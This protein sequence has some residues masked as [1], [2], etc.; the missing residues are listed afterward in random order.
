MNHTEASKKEIQQ[1]KIQFILPRLVPYLTVAGLVL[2][3]YGLAQQSFQVGAVLTALFLYQMIC[4]LLQSRKRWYQGFLWVV[5]I[6]GVVLLLLQIQQ[7]IQ[8]I[9][10]LVNQVIAQVNQVYDQA[11]MSL[12]ATGCSRWDVAL[13]SC[14]TGIFLLQ[15]WNGILSRRGKLGVSFL[16]MVL[17]LGYSLLPTLSSGSGGILILLSW[18]LCWLGTEEEP[19]QL[20]Y[21]RIGL[22]IF[23]V[24]LMFVLSYNIPQDASSANIKQ[25]QQNMKEKAQEFR[26]GSDTLPE[27]DLTKA[28]EI[29]Q[30]DEKRLSISYDK[31]G[32]LY[33]RGYVGGTYTGSGWI[34]LPKSNYIQ[35]NTNGML[36]WLGRKHF[37]TTTQYYQYCTV[38]DYD[39]TTMNLKVTNLNSNRKYVYAP[40]ELSQVSNGLQQQKMDW[41]LQSTGLFGTGSYQMRVETR[42]T[43]LEYMPLEIGNQQEQTGQAFYQANQVY[44]AFVQQ[45][46]TQIDEELKDYLNTVFFQDGD[47]ENASLSEI[48]ARIRLKLQE[49]MTYRDNPVAYDG[50]T[51]FVHWV[52][53]DAREGN[54]E[55]YATI[56]ALAYRSQGIPAR[57]VE[58]YYLSAGDASE[59]IKQ[60][61]GNIVLTTKNA[62]A[63]LEIY[64]EPIGWIPIEVAPGFYYAQYTTQQILNQPQT[65]VSIENEDDQEQLEGSTAD[66]L[67]SDGNKQQNTETTR[68]KIRHITGGLLL[69]ILILTALLMT[70]QIQGSLRRRRVLTTQDIYDQVTALLHAMKL[71]VNMYYPLEARAMVLEAFP[72]MH[73]EEYDRFITLIQKEIFGKE[74]LKP[75]E[76]RYLMEFRNRLGEAVFRR[77]SLWA[78]IRIHYIEC[79]M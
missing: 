50:S 42:G 13:F 1:N 29:N 15:L 69:V 21:G 77:S 12:S 34:T 36:E 56:A 28:A 66:T 20:S 54:T 58:G 31:I 35:D 72:Q 7:M 32:E 60:G 71:P 74:E 52:L 10:F 14:I 39:T 5:N 64:R 8:V 51:D 78:R 53:E 27:G 68:D 55:Y 76:R 47:W 40:Y 65:T 62:H 17:L 67:D 46:Y 24:I 6:L 26:Y 45:A 23:A 11:W 22:G 19:R 4:V 79:I 33:L 43:S 70:I 73:P 38:Q 37:Q 9:R 44:Q 75:N 30:G 61:Q 59:S 63:W 16:Y 48:S 25:L 49:Q 2:G 41:Q 18:I 57:V 3:C